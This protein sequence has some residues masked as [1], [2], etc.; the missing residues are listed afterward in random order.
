MDQFIAVVENSEKQFSKIKFCP[1]TKK[2]SI[3]ETMFEVLI[4][5]L[6]MHPN[7]IDWGYSTLHLFFKM[8]RNEEIVIRWSPEEWKYWKKILVYLTR[9]LPP[10][11][12]TALAA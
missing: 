1:Q 2:V 4:P 10:K 3:Q 11:K 8:A 9:H 5:H 7:D 12:G 6:K